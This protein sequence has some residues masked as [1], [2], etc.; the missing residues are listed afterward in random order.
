MPFLHT[1]EYKLG[2]ISGATL[3]KNL[4]F[5]ADRDDDE[6]IERLV[7]TAYTRARE[8]LTL[9]YSHMDTSERS[10]EPLHC[11][12]VENSEWDEGVDIEVS[13]LSDTLD[14]DR[15]H[16]FAIPYSDEESHFL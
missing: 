12:S 10:N 8:S 13:S 16:L 1:R 14:A 5:E 9:S 4:P 6:D 15:H 7:Y 3:P 2:R 11:I